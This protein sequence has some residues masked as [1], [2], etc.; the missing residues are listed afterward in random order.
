MG[1]WARGLR[2]RRAH[3]DRDAS[4]DRYKC[5]RRAHACGAGQGLL[6]PAFYFGS[7]VGA[8][9]RARAVESAPSTN[10]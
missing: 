10:V 2:R 5:D 3:R 4:Q 9:A 8:E 7:R 6:V 1:E